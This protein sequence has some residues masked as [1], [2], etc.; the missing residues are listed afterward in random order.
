MLLE[1]G[2]DWNTDFV[3]RTFF[4]SNKDKRLL[5]NDIL[6]NS[7]GVGSIGNVDLF[8]KDFGCMTDGHVS[9]L[10][11]KDFNEILPK[12]LLY[13]LRSIFGQMQIERFTVG[14]TGQ[15]EL[16]RS[17]LEQIIVAYP[18]STKEQREIIKTLEELEE[19][20]LNYKNKARENLNKISEEFAKNVLSD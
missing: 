7:T 18:E 2:I 13:Y 20:A 3:H 14:Y 4:E 16:N 12:Y 1:K 11:I 17:D 9:V 15:V 8:D 10:R 6:L 5:P 19:E